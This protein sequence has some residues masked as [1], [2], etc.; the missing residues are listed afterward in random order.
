MAGAAVTALPEFEVF[1]GKNGRSVQTVT[2]PT[3]SIGRQGGFTLN[4]TAYETLGRPV[5]VELLYDRSKRIIG[6]RPADPKGPNSYKVVAT[7]KDLRF[8]IS[9]KAFMTFYGIDLPTV[10]TA[11]RWP[12]TMIDGVLCVNLNDPPVKVA[13]GPSQER[14]ITCAR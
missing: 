6:I 13:K 9:G 3:L 1:Q 11:L 12:V 5:A 10:T 8:E 2:E 4:R 7:Y 14:H